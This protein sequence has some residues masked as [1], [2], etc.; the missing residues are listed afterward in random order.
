MRYARAAEV[1]NVAK[2]Q[3]LANMSH[4]LRTPMNAILG[5]IDVALPKVTDPTAR[6]CLHTAKDS[7][8]LL[9]ALLNDLLDTTKI[10]SG[11]LDLTTAPFNL[12]RMLEQM[13]QI[14]DVRAREK[15]LRFYCRISEGTPEAVVGGSHAIAASPAQS[16]WKRHQVH[17]TGRSGDPRSRAVTDGRGLPGVRRA[18]HGHRHPGCQFGDCSSSPSPK[19]MLP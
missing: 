8:D 13:T 7:A 18:R 10:E 5:M 4:E 14:L 6:D 11:R 19:P 15:G 3:F 17:G 1:A 12:R 16:L 9:L 2:S